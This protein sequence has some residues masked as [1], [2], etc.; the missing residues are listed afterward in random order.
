MEIKIQMILDR[1]AKNTVR[2][3]EA[4]NPPKLYQGVVYIQKSAFG[5]GENYPRE[6]ELT[7]AAKAKLSAVR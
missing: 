1:E 7:I 6:L 4:T 2:Y 5:R 3:M